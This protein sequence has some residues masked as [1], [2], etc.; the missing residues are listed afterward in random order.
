[1]APHPLTEFLLSLIDTTTF[2]QYSQA[3]ETERRH[4][5]QSAGLSSSQIDVVINAKIQPIVD[6]VNAELHPHAHHRGAKIIHL[7]IA[8]GLPQTDR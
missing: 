2:N 5:M 8:V 4:M 1:M 6:A 3:D 7:Q